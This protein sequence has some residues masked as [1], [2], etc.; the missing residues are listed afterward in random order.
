[1][2]VLNFPTLILVGKKMKKEFKIAVFEG[3]GIGPEIMAP[4]ISILCWITSQKMD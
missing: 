3:D 1:M 2:D 4:T